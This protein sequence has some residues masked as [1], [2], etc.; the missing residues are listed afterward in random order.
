MSKDRIKGTALN[1]CRRDAAGQIQSK[2]GDTLGLQAFE[3]ISAVEGIRL[4]GEMRRDILLAS[5]AKLGPAERPGLVTGK[6][7]KK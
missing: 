6:Y 4:S 2:R 3:R 7:G 1:S 5:D